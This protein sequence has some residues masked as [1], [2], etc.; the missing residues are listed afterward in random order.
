[1]Q[2]R[3]P[4]IN[5]TL[6]RTYAPAVNALIGCDIAPPSFKKRSVE[7]DAAEETNDELMDIIEREVANLD[8]HFKVRF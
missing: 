1:M 2:A 6:Q 8:P 5:H 3:S 7:K 4:Y